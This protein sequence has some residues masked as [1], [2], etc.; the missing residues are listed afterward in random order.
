[1]KTKFI[2]NSIMSLIVMAS[3]TAHAGYLGQ[4]SCHQAYLESV[5]QV[6]YLNM[7]DFYDYDEMGKFF[8]G[9]P[10][11]AL[12]L[13]IFTVAAPLIGT[14]IGIENLIRHSDRVDLETAANILSEDRQKNELALN[15]IYPWFFTDTS[16]EYSI[17]DEDKEKRNV[18]ELRSALQ[19]IKETPDAL[20]T[21]KAEVLL[22]EKGIKAIQPH[23]SA[24]EFI[25]AMQAQ[26]KRDAID[27][28]L[29]DRSN[30]RGEYVRSPIE[31][32]ELKQLIMNEL[33]K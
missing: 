9:K 10:I 30:F 25:F 3:V 26:E 15:K 32:D 7:R 17:L 8:D 33:K 6:Q 14:L 20:C 11:A 23:G 19:R 24:G 18:E 4:R 31:K 12:T 16:S 5:A 13:G 21:M 1:M 2:F 29:R 28:F 22:S 27:D